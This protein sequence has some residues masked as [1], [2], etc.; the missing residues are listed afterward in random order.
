MY[1]Y[2]DKVIVYIFWEIKQWQIIWS[3]G[4]NLYIDHNR[5]AT[6]ITEDEIIERV[7]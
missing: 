1:K 3:K 4:D 2:W 6:K 7:N 5:G